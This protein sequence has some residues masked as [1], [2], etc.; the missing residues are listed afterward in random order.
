VRSAGAFTFSCIAACFFATGLAYAQ[1]STD[2]PPGSPPGRVYELPVD[3]GRKDGAPRGGESGSNSSGSTFRSENNFGTSANVPGD[4]G[5]GSSG[6]SGSGGGNGGS[7]SGGSGTGGDDAVSGLEKAATL[8]TGNPSAGGGYALLIVVALGGV[9]LGV[10][11][12]RTR[13]SNS[14]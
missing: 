1:V 7:G 5:G 9:L 10:A 4:P 13:V 12:A 8:D 11:A 2:P 3:T 6:S 14:R